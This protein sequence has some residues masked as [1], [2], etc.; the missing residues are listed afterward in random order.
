MTIPHNFSI[1]APIYDSSVSVWTTD[2]PPE[3]MNPQTE[4]FCNLLGIENKFKMTDAE[5]QAQKD[6]INSLNARQASQPQ[7][8]R[9]HGRGGHHGRRGRGRGRG[10][11]R[12]G[13][14]G[15]H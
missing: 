4:Q 15:W 7:D 5:K 1:T 13:G 9:Q 10:G 11:F 6:A 3:Y 2:Q 14:R 8:G 12:G